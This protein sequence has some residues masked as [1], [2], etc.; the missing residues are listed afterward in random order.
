MMGPAIVV[1]GATGPVGRRVVAGLVAGGAPVRAVTRNPE[2]APATGG[3]DF[4][5]AQRP[6]GDLTAGARSVLVNITALGH[7]DPTADPGAR[8]DE[9]LAAADEHGVAHLVL[10]SSVSALDPESPIGAGYRPLEDRIANFTGTATILRSVLFASNTAH[11]WS[12]GIRQA[13]VAAAPYPDVA[14]TPIDDRDVAAVITGALLEG[15]AAAGGEYL[16]TGPAAL[17]PRELVA[18]I[19]EVLGIAISFEE[20]PPDTV[21]RGLLDAGVP[22]WAADGLLRS[23]E[24]ARLEPVAPSTAVQRFTGRPARTYAE[25][26]TGHLELF[27]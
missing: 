8:L 15:P 25:W 3:V 9:L 12:A 1:T 6:F 11:W 14:V 16:L 19:A 20:V 26:V 13:R 10:L 4:V 5:S 17:T 21:R 7:G 24:Y 23:F 27:R 22:A 18:T 2:S